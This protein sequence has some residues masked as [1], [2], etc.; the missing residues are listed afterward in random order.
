MIGQFGFYRAL[1][2]SLA[3]VQ[4]VY[5][6]VLRSQ[7][8][9]TDV[10]IG[11]KQKRTTTSTSV[12]SVV[13]RSDKFNRDIEERSRQ[14]AANKGPGGSMAA[15]AVLGGLIGGPFGAL[16]GAQIGANL[17][18]KSNLDRARKEEMD[19][20][21]ITQDMLDA[22][23][24][25][26]QAL[27]QSMDGAEATKNSLSTHQALARR[28]DRDVNELYDK[29]K[30]SMAAGDEEA[31]RSFLLKRNDN[32][33]SLKR[34]LQMCADEKKRMEIMEQNVSALQRRATEVEALLTRTVG[35]KARQGSLTDFSVSSEDPLLR[36]FRDLGID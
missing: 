15:G 24:A 26:G 16:F 30:E 9:Y 11:I 34:V 1:L 3:V 21:G 17:G 35:A 14:R 8:Q 22:A 33:E 31:A 2:L 10:A 5:G 23:Q 27:K 25:V 6:F 29:A 7:K 28:I 36:K 12:I 18:G 32:Q 20:L 4:V 19:R 13:L